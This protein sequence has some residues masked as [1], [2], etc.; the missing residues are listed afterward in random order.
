ML[1]LTKK[2]KNKK[3]K[4]KLDKMQKCN[5]VKKKKHENGPPQLK[6][7]QILYLKPQTQEKH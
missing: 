6:S 3:M 1:N 2:I 5:G 7:F 4:R